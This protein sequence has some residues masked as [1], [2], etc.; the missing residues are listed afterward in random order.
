M[1]AITATEAIRQILKEKG[2]S[3]ATLSRRT[4]LQQSTARERLSHDNISVKKLNEM[5][6]V[7]DYKVVIQPAGK[8]LVEGAI[9]IK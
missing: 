1:G 5:L 3:I 4:G 6:A 8:K 9:E 2:I 7:L